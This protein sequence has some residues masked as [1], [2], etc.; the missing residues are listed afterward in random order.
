VIS[1]LLIMMYGV[2]RLTCAAQACGEHFYLR[3]Q[4]G[5]R[6]NNRTRPREQAGAQR[7]RRAAGTWAADR[8]GMGYCCAPRACTL[9]AAFT[10]F[11]CIP[12]TPARTLATRRAR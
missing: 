2:R 10:T 3:A 5:C 4:A 11:H 6:V 7:G 12:P 8:C 9:L 1:P